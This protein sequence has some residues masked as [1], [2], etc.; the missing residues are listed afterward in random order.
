MLTEV[1][2]DFP[3]VGKPANTQTKL[4]WKKG[5]RKENG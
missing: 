4:Y 1:D 2:T 5:D 3:R